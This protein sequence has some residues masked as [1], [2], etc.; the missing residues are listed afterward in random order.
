MTIMPIGTGIAQQYT[1]TMEGK[2]I[3]VHLRYVVLTDKWLISL[4]R[5]GVTILAGQRLVMGTDL[6]SAHNF[7]LGSIFLFDNRLEGILGDHST[8]H[9]FGELGD[10][11]QDPGRNELGD[12]ILLIHAS[13][14]E[15]SAAISA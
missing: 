14:A 10:P 4:E 6:L 9:A 7:K 11:G 8:E 5:D 3:I 13:E 2:T 1:F 15:K 12:T